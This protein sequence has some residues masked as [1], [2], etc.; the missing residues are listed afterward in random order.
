MTMLYRLHVTISQ[1]SLCLLHSGFSL[2]AV[3]LLHRRRCSDFTAYDAYCVRNA[4]I[5]SRTDSRCI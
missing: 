4:D 2:H 3:G 5:V 1:L